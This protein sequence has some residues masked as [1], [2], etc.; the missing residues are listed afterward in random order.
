[1]DTPGLAVFD[2]PTGEVR[3]EEPDTIA[4]WFIAGTT[5][6]RASLFARPTFSA[7]TPP[8][9][10]SRPPSKQRSIWFR[11]TA[12]FLQPTTSSTSIRTLS[13]TGPGCW[14]CWSSPRPMAPGRRRQRPTAAKA[15][16]PRWMEVQPWALE[17]SMPVR[18]GSGLRECP[19]PPPSGLPG[20][21]VVG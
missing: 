19:S 2:P 6:G 18:H 21:R 11:R 9:R 13:F 3:S 4:S 17:F 7:K 12:P 10:A 1:M 8:I 15:L 20:L 5:M 14:R 16:G